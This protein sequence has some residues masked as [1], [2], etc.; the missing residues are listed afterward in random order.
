MSSAFFADVYKGTYRGKIVATKS[1]AKETPPT[2]FFQVADIWTA[3]KHPNV[4]A[5]S[6]TDG[7]W[8]AS[9]GPCFSCTRTRSMEA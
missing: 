4:L 5:L 9:V 7:E 6:G 3:L 1:L 2:L 8:K